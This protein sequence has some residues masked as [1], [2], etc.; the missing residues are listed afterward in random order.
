MFQKVFFH[1]K[2][3]FYVKFN[4]DF[5]YIDDLEYKLN[6]TYLQLCLTLYT[7]TKNP[8]STIWDILGIFILFYRTGPNPHILSQKVK[9]KI[10]DCFEVTLPYKLKN[11]KF[12]F[13]FEILLQGFQS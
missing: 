11:R 2:W 3:L 7:M 1:N 13:E 8:K 12:L 4:I 6:L 10:K 9:K 5:K